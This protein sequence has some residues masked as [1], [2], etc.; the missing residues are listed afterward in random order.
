MHNQRKIG[1]TNSHKMMELR[2]HEAVNDT[3]NLHECDACKCVFFEHVNCQRLHV[4]LH[5]QLTC[6]HCLHVIC[7]RLHVDPRSHVH[8]FHAHLY[9][10]IL[11]MLSQL[12]V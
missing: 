7:L 5:V 2:L 11:S 6:H 8:T 3:L 9:E 1:V 10:T 12:I 4:S